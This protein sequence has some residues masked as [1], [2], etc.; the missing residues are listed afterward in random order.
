MR[1]Y[2]YQEAILQQRPAAFWTSRAGVTL[3]GTNVTHWIDRVAGY[4]A[5]REDE[6]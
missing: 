4:D 1:R 6:R 5:N 3:S 2:R